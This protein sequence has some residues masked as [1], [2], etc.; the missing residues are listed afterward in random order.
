MAV[1]AVFFV[2]DLV[3][4]APLS[5]PLALSRSLLESGLSINS[6]GVLQSIADLSLGGRLAVFTGLHLAVF[7]LF[8]V[9]AAGLANLFHV[10]W[11][12]RSG[13]VAGLI[14]GLAAWLVASRAGPVWMAS[15]RLTPEVIVGAAILG[16]AVLG[17][18]LRLCHIDAQDAP[19]RAGAFRR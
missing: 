9:L 3:R 12:A 10:R 8:G 19:T 2:V 1:A 11:S 6:A 17:W 4:A 18:H 15:A 13:A 7:A 5:T 14:I 16:G